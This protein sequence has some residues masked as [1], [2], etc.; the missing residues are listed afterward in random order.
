MSGG[1]ESGGNPIIK[2]MVQ[3][4]CS[5]CT[6]HSYHTVLFELTEVPILLM[7]STVPLKIACYLVEVYTP[8]FSTHGMRYMDVPYASCR[9]T[10]TC[11]VD[12]I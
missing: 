6:K 11:T 8:S 4:N 5:Y 3:K 1:C 7:H 12:Q 2:S 10:C 9:A